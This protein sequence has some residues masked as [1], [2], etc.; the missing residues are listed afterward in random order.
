MP[1]KTRNAKGSKRPIA[2]VGDENQP[3]AK[4][5]NV[6]REPTTSEDASGS[7]SAVPTT[8]APRISRGPNGEAFIPHIIPRECVDTIKKIGVPFSWISYVDATPGREMTLGD[9][10]WWETHG[11]WLEK[12]KTALK[13]KAA[14]WKKKDETMSKD[15]PRKEDEGNED[16]DF[17]CYP[18]PRDSEDDEDEEED[19]EEE[20]NDEAG[21]NKDAGSKDKNNP[22]GKLASLHPDHPWVFSMLGQDRSRWWI[23]EAMK[24]DQDEF[25]MHIYNDF[26]SYGKLE[27]LENIFLHFSAVCKRKASYQ[28]LWPE[29][30]GLALVLRSDVSDFV[31]CDDGEKCGSMIKMVGHLVMTTLKSLKDQKV[32]TA[33]SAIPNIGLVLAIFVQW[34]WQLAKDF[35]WEEESSWVHPVVE[36]A[37]KAQITLAGPPGFE[38]NLE[39]IKDNADEGQKHAKVWKATWTAACAAFRRKHGTSLTPTSQ[40][41][42]GGSNY[43]ITK[44]SAAQR[45]Q[46]SLGF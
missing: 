45:K 30:E 13:L 26:S 7:S 37:E 15:V 35:S 10:V 46:H 33:D 23:L 19:E 1:P 24:R 2:D 3:A 42:L 25:G 39:E 17:I 34:A 28:E 9:R 27:V 43:D 11:P 40:Q 41:T 32:L 6:G 8:N 18:L 31:M 5:S 12:N 44:F 4:K 38:E 14:D 29:V 22:V 36:M 21:G 16:F 20:E